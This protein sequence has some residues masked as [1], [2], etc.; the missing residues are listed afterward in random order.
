MLKGT[1][2]GGWGVGFRNRWEHTR[3][4]QKEKYVGAPG[5]GG[6]CKRR[7]A[8][9]GMWSSFLRAAITKVPKS[10]VLQQ[11]KVVSQFWKVKVEIRVSAGLLPPES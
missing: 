5:K 7:S 6:D 10:G 2:R 11:Q 9:E 8:W 3:N 4:G 1:G